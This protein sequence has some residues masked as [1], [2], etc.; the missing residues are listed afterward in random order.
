[1]NITYWAPNGTRANYFRAWALAALQAKFPSAEITVLPAI[2]GPRYRVTDAN[3]TILQNVHL[4]LGALES[5]FEAMVADL[6][7]PARC[8][9]P[10]CGAWGDA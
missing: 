6:D 9:C 2:D 10:T 5:K 3:I 1:M 7:R 8:K 4:F